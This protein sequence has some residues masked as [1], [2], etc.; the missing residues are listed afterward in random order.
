MFFFPLIHL[1]CMISWLMQFSDLNLKIIMEAVGD[2]IIRRC[3]L[4]ID[5][6]KEEAN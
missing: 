5:R 1:L 3:S 6:P 2:S 4:E